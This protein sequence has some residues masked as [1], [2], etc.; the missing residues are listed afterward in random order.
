MRAKFN[1]RKSSV[2]SL[3]CCT[4][5]AP[6][7][8]QRAGQSVS[9][10]YGTIAGSR[11]VDLSSG[12]VPGGALVGGTLGLAS[13]SGKS[14]GK[15]ARNVVIGAAAT[16]AVAGA[17]QG[18]TKGMLY[19]VDLASQGKIQVVS[20]QRE[21]QKGDCVAVEKAGETAN[22]RRVTAAYCEGG[23]DAAV[24]AVATNAAHEAQECLDAKQ[25]LVDAKTD[26]AAELAGKKVGLLCND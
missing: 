3:I 17:A 15:K 2:V 9:V 23:N 20:D 16:A 4:L 12:A 6:A 8:A 24:K 10:Q 13:A 1:L 19:D 22:L 18:N 25:Q 14:S 7:L 11:E 26:D 21:I 5:V